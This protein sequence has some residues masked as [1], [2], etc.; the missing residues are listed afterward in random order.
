MRMQLHHAQFALTQQEVRRLIEA[1]P[2]PRERTLLEVLYWYGLRREEARSL[3]IEDIDWTH[4]LIRIRGKSGKVRIVPTLNPEVLKH[5]RALANGASEGP[6]FTGPSGRPL[7]RRT[8]NFLVA[9]CARL[10]GISVPNPARKHVHPHLLR[11]SLARHLKDAGFSLEFIK[12]LLGH[13]SVATTVDLYGPMSLQDMLREAL[14]L[15]HRVV[16]GIRGVPQR[17][18]ARN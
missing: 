2:T 18:R 12:N 10:A 3:R 14:R 9:K 5:L 16:Q 11:H 15:R 17:K 1:A 6:V 7:A 8:I 13:A 4:G